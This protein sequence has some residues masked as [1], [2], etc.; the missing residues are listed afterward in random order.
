MKKYLIA[1]ALLISIAIVVAEEVGL[2]GF[3]KPEIA[4]IATVGKGL[5]IS[6]TD[7]FEFYIIK[8]GM[9]K[10]KL[11]YEKQN[12]TKDVGLLWVDDQK[13]QLKDINITQDAATANIYLNNTH[14]GSLNLV[15]VK[16]GETFV[17]VGK[18]TIDKVE[19][20]VYIVEGK[21]GFHKNEILLRVRECGDE[22]ENC[23]EIAKGIGNRFCEKI[24]TTSCR[25]KIAEFCEQNQEDPR[26]VAIMKSF[27]IN[28]TE[29]MRC[30]GIMTEFCKR[31]P[32]DAR[33]SHCQD[34][35]EVCGLQVKA[36][37]NEKVRERI[38]E[39]QKKVKG[40]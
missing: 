31:N 13:Y 39:M 21:R 28:N 25:E 3:G 14:V 30:R 9:M 15:L 32:T 27:C 12:I 11:T 23:K 22:D 29:D 36:K 19:Y 38:Q 2:Q 5:A 4:R 34:N 24:N 7:N 1:L 33:C 8:V 10:V 37:I 17:W 20:N 18:M 26:C 40:R 35:P 16:K 6:T